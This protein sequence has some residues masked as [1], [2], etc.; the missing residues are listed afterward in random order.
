VITIGEATAH[1][2]SASHEDHD[3]A[4]LPPV[5]QDRKRTPSASH[6][7]GNGRV[8]LTGDVQD[9]PVS[10]P[11]KISASNRPDVVATCAAVASKLAGKVQTNKIEG[12]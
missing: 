4:C 3:D 11:R 12:R 9:L 6:V 7:T 2:T 8:T 5:L 10:N 1:P